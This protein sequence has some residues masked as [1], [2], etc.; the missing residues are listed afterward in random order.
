MSSWDRLAV[1]LAYGTFRKLGSRYAATTTPCP[2]WYSYLYPYRLLYY[3]EW[4]AAP[5]MAPVTPEISLHSSSRG[6]HDASRRGLLLNISGPVEMVDDPCKP[7]GLLQTSQVHNQ[8]RLVT[9]DSWNYLYLSFEWPLWILL[10]RGFRNK[11]EKYRMLGSLIDSTNSKRLRLELGTKT[12]TIVVP[13]CDYQAFT[14]SICDPLPLA[15]TDCPDA[16][17]HTQKSRMH[18]AYF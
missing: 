17:E 10:G 6:S 9:A 14:V 13:N 16:D 1:Q 7:P 3:C 5:Q 11:S 15:G 12:V 2:S 4:R 18:L 8:H